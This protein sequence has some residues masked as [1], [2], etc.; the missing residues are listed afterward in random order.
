[1]PN[2]QDTGQAAEKLIVELCNDMGCSTPDD[3]ANVLEL[4]IS[5]AARATEKYSGTERA[6]MSCDRTAHHLRKSIAN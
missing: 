3:V 2:P 1:M 5:K 6:L 4:L